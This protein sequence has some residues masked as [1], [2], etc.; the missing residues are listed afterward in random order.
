M[1]QAKREYLSAYLFATGT[2]APTLTY[3]QSLVG[4]ESGV[5]F[6]FPL[7][8]AWDSMTVLQ[9]EPGDLNAI[10]ALVTQLTEG[11]GDRDRVHHFF[12]RNVSVV[13]VQH[14]FED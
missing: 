2:T 1:A 10:R 6:V 5:H 12:M 11:G 13:P 3:A 9:V 7:V 8:G 14:L 4:P